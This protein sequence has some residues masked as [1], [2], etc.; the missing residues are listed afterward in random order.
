MEINI[1][2]SK[3]L[4][5]LFDQN[6]Y[7]LTNKNQAIIIDAGAELEDVIA[8]VGNRKVLAILMT[9]LHFDHFWNLDKYL[10][11]FDCK[12][13]IKEN[14]EEKF[15][16]GKLNGSVLIKK[17]FTKIISKKFIKYYAKK[18]EL[19]DF[20]IEVFETSG[21]SADSVCLLVQGVL[22]TGDTVFS[23]AIG[24]TDL[25]DSSNEK[26]LESL[27]LIKN[28]DFERA[29]PGHYETATKNEILKTIS[30][31]L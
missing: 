8:V 17:E 21:H 10:E 23:D 2:K 9:H 12:V 4:R 28:I 22:F 31:Y 3:F 1:I 26:M 14:C 15:E 29:Y 11:K 24:R 27:K 6:T 5:G 25:Q 19:G 18:L 7:V 30:F 20:S 13:F 16:N